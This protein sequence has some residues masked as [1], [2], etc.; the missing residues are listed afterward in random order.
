MLA[1]AALDT[2]DADI[3]IGI[4]EEGNRIA[5]RKP[6]DG[7]DPMERGAETVVGPALHEIAGIHEQGPRHRRRGMPLPI[8]AANF[9][10]ADVILMEQRDGPVIGVCSGA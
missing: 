7:A 5:I 8:A 10:S 9:Q 4:H 3:R 6:A 2:L 1:A